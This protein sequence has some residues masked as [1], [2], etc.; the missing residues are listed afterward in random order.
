MRGDFSC[1]IRSGSLASVKPKYVPF[2][3]LLGALLT[4]HPDLCSGDDVD[5]RREWRGDWYPRSGMG[6][7][8]QLGSDSPHPGA[9]AE[10][11]TR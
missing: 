7:H 3:P 4:E 11:K 2:S 8:L 9:C 5:G 6:E 1:K 10:W